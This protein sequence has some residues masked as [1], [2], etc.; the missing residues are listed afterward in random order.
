MQKNNILFLKY[1]KNTESAQL[2]IGH[3][4]V[5]H[6]PT[7]QDTSARKHKT[8]SRKDTITSISSQGVCLTHP[9]SSH[10]ALT[11]SWDFQIQPRHDGETLLI[12][13]LLLLLLLL[14]H[15]PAGS[16]SPSL[17]RPPWTWP[18]GRG[19]RPEAGG[20]PP[21][22]RAGQ[23]PR[24]PPQGGGGEPFGR[25]RG[26]GGVSGGWGGISGRA[27]GHVAF[28]NIFFF[29]GGFLKVI[30]IGSLT[31]AGMKTSF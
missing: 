10:T 29:R 22:A 5:N 30:P 28:L 17:G 14:P 1:L 20:Q 25:P 26:V 21:P 6:N 18:R 8:E 12:L 31:Y 7:R 19:Q 27:W 13:L 11:A 3:R 9:F 23:P 15:L 2:W 24:R 16:C 4:S